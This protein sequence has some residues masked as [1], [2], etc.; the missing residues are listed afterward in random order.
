M[1]VSS[2]KL[3]EG[4]ILFMQPFKFSGI[5]LSNRKIINIDLK[6]GK[7]SGRG[8][9]APLEFFGTES[10]SF[11]IETLQKFVNDFSEFE[12]ESLD[13][14][15][16]LLD[17]NAKELSPCSTAAFEQALIALYSNYTGQKESQVYRKIFN[18]IDTEGIK[19]FP[20]TKIPL[21]SVIAVDKKEDIPEKIRNLKN[22]GYRAF[23]LK[24]GRASLSEDIEIVALCR[25]ISGEDIILRLDANCKLSGENIINAINSFDRFN[26]QYIEQPVKDLSELK[27]FHESIKIKLA[28]DEQIL[29]VSEAEKIIE[30]KLANF[31]I[32]K[33]PFLGGVIKSYRLMRKA[34][35]KGIF[36]TITSALQSYS[37]MLPSIY[38]TS[39]TN[40]SGYAGFDTIKLLSNQ[41]TAIIE[42]GN[43]ILDL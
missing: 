19:E 15:I 22:Q 17:K 21:N 37:G 8:E 29:S 42:N 2:V 12:I 23:K 32:I 3:S 1:I 5:S 33:P 38:L 34:E 9:A 18:I 25:E 14:I 26:P 43:L 30:N 40:H 31:L 41:E 16:N 7:H 4:E 28:A 24:I 39:N 10:Y 35:K 13:D 27:R 6:S 20:E 11:A 36:C